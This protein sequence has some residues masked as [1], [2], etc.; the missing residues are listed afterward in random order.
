MPGVR[1]GRATA[2]GR[3]SLIG[4]FGSLSPHL[5]PTDP[6]PPARLVGRRHHG[7]T[8]G[9][10]ASSAAAPTHRFPTQE[11]RMVLMP[12]GEWPEPHRIVV[13][14]DWHGNIEWARY[15]IKA[16]S[17]LLPDEPD[18]TILHCGDFGFDPASRA[19]RWYLYKVGQALADV[20]A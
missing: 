14:G 10:L 19:G 8:G 13:A 9:Q 5:R 12:L 15:A 20:D 17:A 18:R 6:A 4:G 2:A 1:A 11:G 3:R 7:H 16:V